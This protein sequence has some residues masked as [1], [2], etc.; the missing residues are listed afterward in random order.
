MRAISAC[1]PCK[2]IKQKCGD[3]RPCARCKRLGRVD[4]CLSVSVEDDDSKELIERPV[5]YPF[6]HFDLSVDNALPQNLVLKYDWSYR[7][8]MIYWHSGYKCEILMNLFNSLPN[9]LSALMSVV[10]L[11]LQK[12]DSSNVKNQISDVSRSPNLGNTDSTVLLEEA[13]MWDREETYG[14]MEVA[15]HPITKQRQHMIMN[16]RFA[17][18]YG[19]HK[20]ELYSRFASHEADLQR[21]EIDSLLLMLDGLQHV[22]DDSKSAAVERYY[23]MYSGAERQPILVWTLWGKAVN[24]IGQV[25]KASPPS[26]HVEAASS[27]PPPR[28]CPVCLF[29]CPASSLAR[30]RRTHGVWKPA[31]HSVMRATQPL[32]D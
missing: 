17:N 1:P 2:R 16:T 27:A 22:L 18:I 6:F 7:T 28:L 8:V 19:F 30:R 21:T 29:P 20:E 31:P 13:S 3:F 32:P 10:S 23:R 11:A 24:S 12:R 25:F 5:P 15:L 26:L 9:E 14:F 4:D